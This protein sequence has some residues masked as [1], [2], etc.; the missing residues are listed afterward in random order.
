MSVTFVPDGNILECGLQT[1]AIP[2][3]CVGVAGKGLAKEAA[4]VYPDW[5]LQYVSACKSAKVNVDKKPFIYQR[6]NT[7]MFIIS[8][9]TKREWWMPSQLV[10]IE[11]GLQWLATNGVA[12]GITEMG[13]PQLGCGEGGLE[14]ANVRALIVDL[15]DDHPIAVTV[16]GA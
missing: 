4:G 6:R 16:F 12:Q 2:V 13:L 14:W 9:P 3:N 15:F 11:R 5:L 1:I 8:F 10:W 7:P